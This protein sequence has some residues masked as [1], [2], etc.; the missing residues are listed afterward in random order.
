MLFLHKYGNCTGIKLQILHNVGMGIMEELK[1]KW[2]NPTERHVH[3]II[4]I[5][6]SIN[7]DKTCLH[8]TCKFIKKTEIPTPDGEDHWMNV[9]TSYWDFKKDDW[10]IN[11][12]LANSL[13]TAGLNLIVYDDT[14]KG[15]DEDRFFK[16]LY[17]ARIS[18]HEEH[19]NNNILEI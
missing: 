14:E 6:C 1:D 11:N 17:K 19:S 18:Y 15:I 4:N 12:E 7:E 16:L 3:G 8:Q 2:E 9:S 10:V 5:G 13:D